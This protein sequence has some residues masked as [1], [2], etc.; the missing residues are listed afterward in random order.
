MSKKPNSSNEKA[1]PAAA[2]TKNEAKEPLIHLTKRTDFSVARA[3][4]IR[5][6]AFFVA[7]LVCGA[8]AFILIKS[9]RSEPERI[10]E[11]YKSFI[12]GSF[13]NEDRVWTFLKDLSILLC[14]SLALTPAFRMKYWN[15][16]AE[17]Q[18][19]MGIFGCIAVAVYFG[20]SVSKPLL[21]V[22][23]LLGA[24]LCGA[25]WAL[26][27]A[28][29]KSIWNTNETLFTLMMNY[30]ATFFV[31]FFVKIWIPNG[32]SS[33]GRVDASALFSENRTAYLFVILSTVVFTVVM[34]IYLNRTKHGYEISVVGESQNTARYIGINVWKVCIRTNLISGALCGFTGFLLGAGLNQTINPE[35]VGGQGFTAIMVSWLGEFNPALM[36]ITSALIT[37][38][39][40]GGD[41]ILETF[42]L[43]G[44]FSDVI[45]GIILLFIIGC[46]F[47]MNYKIHIR[48]SNKEENKK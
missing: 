9:L 28:I 40:K 14:I 47:F 13:G 8:V 21:I 32:N 26:I 19:L 3:W 41:Q 20:N 12:T 42:N 15:I 7:F 37:F 17:G 10:G 35:S 23:M 38:L 25:I 45:V 22:M 48:K 33:L 11:F 34:Y 30:I 43:R 24:L 4:R 1:A 2:K 16:G 46:E 44:A 18:T 31:A 36:T 5:I 27:P 6:I 29:F 39:N